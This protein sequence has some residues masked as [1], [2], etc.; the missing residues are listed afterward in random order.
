[1]SKIVFKSQAMA[2]DLTVRLKNR[3]AGLTVQEDLDSDRF[4]TL[5]CQT[6]GESVWIRI[7]TDA[8]RSEDD[9]HV[10]SL[11]LPQNVYTPHKT[12]I[13]QEDAGDTTVPTAAYNSLAAQILAEVSKNGTKVI[14]RAGEGVGAAADFAAA[15]TAAA[16]TV[17]EIRSDDIHPLTAQM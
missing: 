9:G 12:E 8:Q 15:D 5:Q 14:V 7:Q 17:A 16:D 11:G 2:R 10:D 6:G 3:I 1:M 4:P 13:L